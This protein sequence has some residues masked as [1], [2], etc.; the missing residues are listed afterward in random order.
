[1]RKLYLFLLLALLVGTAALWQ[2]ARFGR[3]PRPASPP[4][5]P[6][7]PPDRDSDT[8]LL[9]LG[10][11]PPLRPRVDAPKPS[12]RATPLATPSRPDAAGETQVF[13]RRGDTLSS[14]V[15][16]HHASARPALV[17]AFRQR[18]GL[19]SADRLREGAALLLPPLP[20]GLPA[21]R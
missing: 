17:E 10:G 15:R 3:P 2:R 21:G 5:R 7:A 9:A 4:P 12:P 8:L 14:I 16:A 19:A 6:S 13:A 11:G 1:M 18:N 20:A